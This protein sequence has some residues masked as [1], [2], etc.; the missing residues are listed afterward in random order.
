M[1]GFASTTSYYS[2][3]RITTKHDEYSNW[4]LHPV[5]YYNNTTLTYFIKDNNGAATTL[6]RQCGD[7]R[8]FQQRRQWRMVV[9]SGGIQIQWWWWRGKVVFIYGSGGGEG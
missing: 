1:Y 8:K 3:V 5:S 9:R 6:E 2:L 7:G 4:M